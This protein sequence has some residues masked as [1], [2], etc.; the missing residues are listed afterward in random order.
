MEVKN[1][2]EIVYECTGEVVPL[3]TR[4]PELWTV[5][6]L[7]GYRW[8]FSNGLHERVLIRGKG[9]RNT[10]NITAVVLVFLFCSF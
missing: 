10:I 5:K 7:P 1:I 4:Q 6:W 8:L 9:D 2:T 3:I